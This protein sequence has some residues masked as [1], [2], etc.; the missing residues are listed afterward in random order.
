MLSRSK[1]FLFI[2]IP[3]T[4]GNSVQNV[5]KEYS[6][7][8]VVIENRLQDGVERFGLVNR[9]LKTWKH[10]HL[11]FY[12]RA[13]PR[14]MFDNLFK[15]ATVRNP[16]DRMISFYFSPHRQVTEWDPEQFVNMLKEMP[17]MVSYI[18]PRP[19]LLTKLS[20]GRPRIGADFL[21][22]FENLQED[23]DR[24]CAH[25]GIPSQKLPLYNVSSRTHYSEYYDDELIR[26]VGR[27]F[28][29]EI[30]HFNY[31]FERPGETG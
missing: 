31:A 19:R 26:L 5:L 7:D 4:A 8:E 2:H 9:D 18:D 15:F 6:E 1:R 13:L 16:W 11:R 29:F 28:R 10:S 22:R 24:A 14:E 23:F 27:R 17:T 12:K 30:E 3:K 20:I 25:I 21:M